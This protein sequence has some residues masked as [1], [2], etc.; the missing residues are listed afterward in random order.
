MGT[1]P[2]A[3]VPST[4]NS[5]PLALTRAPAWASGNSDAGFVVAGHHGNQGGVRAQGRRQFIQVQPALPVH[6]QQR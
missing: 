3:W 1:L 6:P 5:A 2:T 4:W